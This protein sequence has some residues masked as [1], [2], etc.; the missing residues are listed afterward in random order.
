VIL[1]GA[2]EDGFDEKFV[3][4]LFPDFARK[5]NLVSA[6]SKR[7]VRSL[8]AALNETVAQAGIANR[9]F[10]IVDKDA[11]AYSQPDA[12][13]QE[14][15][16]DVYHVENFLLVPSAIREACASLM[17]GETFESDEAV[18]DALKYEATQLVDR[19]TLERI[20]AEIND[21][22]I[23]AIEIKG[24]PDT[25]DV[26]ASIRPS[27][28]AS[29]RRVQE[30]GATTTANDL[31]RRVEEVRAELQL[32]LQSEEWR[33]VFP[34]RLILRLFVSTHLEGVAYEPFRNVILD[35]IAMSDHRPESMKQILDRILAE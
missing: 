35:K 7:R 4:R 29:V 11:E 15:T 20:Q 2:S 27:I 6:G 3:R 25:H 19:L 26:A 32:A 30:V 34:G 9:F 18:K 10:A 28:E 23:R 1:E 12:Q 17:G 33:S 16:W 8:Y 21:D 13:T 31:S 22:M 5:V 14:F 24:P